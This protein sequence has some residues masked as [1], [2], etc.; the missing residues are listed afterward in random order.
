[1]SF[2]LP[3]ATRFIAL[4]TLVSALSPA[5]AHAQSDRE[6]AGEHY[7][8]GLKAA[9]AADYGEAIFQFKQG[10]AL[11]P[12]GRFPYNLAIVNIKVGKFDEAIRYA[13][14]AEERD[15]DLDEDLRA[16]N[17]ARLRALELRQR[18]LSTAGAI[19]DSTTQAAAEICGD[20]LDND[21]NGRTDCA[22]P[23]CAMLPACGATP[24]PAGREGIGAVGW[25]G[26]GLAV[27]GVG[28]MGSSL[29]F[30]SKLRDLKN[31]DGTIPA[32][33]RDEAVR[34]Q[35]IGLITLGSGGLLA[36]VGTGMFVYALGSRS[37]GDEGAALE[38][39]PTPG[40]ARVD[41]TWRW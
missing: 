12:N 21:A 26:V 38:L 30:N 4:A 6:R 25:S 24:P 15:E 33:N 23:A 36:L 39:A 13:R 11:D 17:S 27:A 35:T 1:M 29:Y 10:Y 3:H 5:V 7:K 40:G 28:L 19:K 14:E 41:M 16:K 37:S 2:D 8:A 20:G 22:D 9:F 31:E 18:A 34:A 32:E